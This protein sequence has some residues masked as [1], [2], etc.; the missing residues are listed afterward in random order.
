MN[1]L[2]TFVSVDPENNKPSIFVQ[3]EGFEPYKLYEVELLK[4]MEE[5]EMD[6]IKDMV[7]AAI[8]SSLN[9]YNAMCTGFV[10]ERDTLMNEIFK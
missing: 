2:K 5:L 3:M 9:E 4:E 1:N 7:K 6:S 10:E 8:R